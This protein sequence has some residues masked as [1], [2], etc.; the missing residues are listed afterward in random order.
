MRIGKFKIGEFMKKLSDLTGERFGRLVVIERAEPY[1][2][3]T[4][5]KCER[6]L[7]RCDCGKEKIVM[8]GHLCGGATV[9]CGCYHSDE[10]RKRNTTHGCTNE[11]LYAIYRGIKVRCYN[12]HHG[13]YKKYGGRGIS[14]CDEWRNNYQAFRDWA[15]QNGYRE[16]ILPNGRSKWTIDRID[17]NGN[18]EPS[19]CRWIT[20]QEQANN[21]SNTYCI[22]HNGKKQTIAEWARELGIPYTALHDRILRNNCDFE[23]AMRTPYKPLRHRKNTV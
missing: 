19:N 11:K 12:P 13:D 9:S 7:V 18:Y 14:M 17:V 5:H 10:V 6:W 2:S 22:E 21:K 1:I 23:K 20:I 4:G 3:P 16:E 15:F 8:R